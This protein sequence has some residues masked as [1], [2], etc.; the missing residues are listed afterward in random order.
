LP[1]INQH[2]TVDQERGDPKPKLTDYL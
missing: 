2:A 1:E